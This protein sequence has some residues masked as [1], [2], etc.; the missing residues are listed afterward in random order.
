MVDEN[1]IRDFVLWVTDYGAWSSG[2]IT[3][4]MVQDYLEHH[5]SFDNSDDNFLLE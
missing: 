4:E 2:N 5:R 3:E 1:A